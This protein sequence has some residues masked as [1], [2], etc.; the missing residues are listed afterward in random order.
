MA[1]IRNIVL[2]DDR[3]QLHPTEVEARVKIFGY[4]ANGPVVQIDTFGS[5]ER[6]I[7]DKLSQTI[8]LDRQ[9]GLQ[10]LE[11]LQRTYR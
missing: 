6:K 8:Q 7:R 9:S 1:R 10:L 4:G 2:G 5:D 11:I 3:G